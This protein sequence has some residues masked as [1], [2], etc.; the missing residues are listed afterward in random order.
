MWDGSF[1]M[2]NIT[3]H[4]IELKY[5]ILKLGKALQPVL[6]ARHFVA[7]EFDKMIKVGIIQLSTSKFSLSV[8]LSP[9]SD[10]YIR[11]CIKYC[12]LNA[13]TKRD[14]YL[15]PKIDDYIVSLGNVRVF[16]AFD[17]NWGYWQTKVSNKSATLA[18]FACQ[19]VFYEFKRI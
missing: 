17:E 19:Q 13:V 15:L 4:H 10:R 16:S 5:K 18:A 14:S 2:N 11:F 8:V 1:G 7:Y 12:L 6:N 9:K 3:R